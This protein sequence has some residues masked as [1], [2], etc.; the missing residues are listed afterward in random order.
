[1]YRV[2]EDGSNTQNRLG[3]IE[4][5]IPPRSRG[6]VFHFHEMHDEGFIITKGVVRFHCPGRPDVDA[7]AGDM[8]MVPL[9]LPHRFSNPFDEE[10]VFMNTTTPA[11][12][13]RYFAYLEELVGEGKELTPEINRAAMLKYATVPLDDEEVA[14][15]EARSAK[16]LVVDVASGREEEA[17]S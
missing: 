2:I 17:K 6:P 3:I 11:H 4:S 5:L 1:L 8:V 14:D 10:A 15:L 7:K 16:S 12:Y 9:R 13:V